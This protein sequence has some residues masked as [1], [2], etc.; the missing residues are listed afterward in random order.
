MK[1]KRFWHKFFT[2]LLTGIFFLNFSIAFSQTK[3]DTLVPALNTSAELEK[4]LTQ[5]MGCLSAVKM[6]P[7]R[8]WLV[9][10][11]HAAGYGASLYGLSS[12]WYSNFNQTK[13]HSFN[14][15][16]EWGG[17]DK[18]GHFVT[19]W[20]I[21]NFSY[22]LFKWTHMRNDRAALVGSS[23]AL[24][25]QTTLEFFDGFAAE[26]GFSWGDMGANLM[27][28][29]FAFFRNTDHLKNVQYKYSFH[30]TPYPNHRSDVLGKT[31]PE[32]MLKDYN[33]Q[34]YWA[35]FNAPSAWFRENRNWLCFSFG[36]SIDGFTGGKENKYDGFYDPAPPNFQRIGELFFSLDVDFEKM[37]IKSKFLKSVLKIFNVVKMPF[38]AI[39]FSTNGKLLL[40]PFYF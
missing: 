17:M 38:P 16:D 26:W 31:L 3:P 4:T 20:Q 33:G 9:T 1:P 12:I 13:L 19:S 21:S 32:Q 30:Q 6:N 5:N 35:S 18:L 11:V 36:Y 28:C 23:V 22:A 39:G 40:K 29:T 10:G 27:G 8:F 7:K 37:H 24:L 15:M 25:Y 14:D 2:S 34:T